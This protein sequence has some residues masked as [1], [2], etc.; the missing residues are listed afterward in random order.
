M[1]LPLL[2]RCASGAA[3]A[4]LLAGCSG[5]ATSAPP[6]ATTSTPSTPTATA[7][8]SAADGEG[9]RLD[10]STEA[11]NLAVVT[12]LFATDP[13]GL[14]PGAQAVVAR[15]AADGDLVAVHW[16]ETTDPTQP[17]SGRARMDLYRLDDGRPT[18]HWA[19]AQD[20]P[21]SG[22]SGNTMF[23]DAHAAAP[24]TPDEAQEESRRQF[25]VA[26]YDTLFRDQDPT[27]LD[28]AFDP[29]YVQHNPLAG[30][31]TAALAQF[32]AGASFPPQESALSLADGDLVWT[33]SRPVGSPTPDAFG[34]GDVFR[35]VD[36]RIVE[37]WDV[38]PAAAVAPTT[39]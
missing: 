30:N 4:V 16:H 18:A 35:V 22:A 12:D 21:A 20:V 7:G 14:A 38:V 32:F 6:A 10:R 27:V 1:K 31:G 28:R 25:V 2:L 29:G 13:P 15:T 11:A 34:A 36:G 23:D 5:S 37:H 26:A 24:T 33:F 8:A 17:W 39:D 9:D 3:A 19:L